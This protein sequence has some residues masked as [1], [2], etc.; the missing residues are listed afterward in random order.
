LVASPQPLDDLERL[1]ERELEVLSLIAL[2]LSNKEIA[3]S[4]HLA[5]ATVKAHVS[6]ILRKM[7]AR[8]R[9]EAAP[10]SRRAPK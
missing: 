5:T 9:T 2:G 3:D 10:M 6:T 4:L 1:T 7:G 8:N